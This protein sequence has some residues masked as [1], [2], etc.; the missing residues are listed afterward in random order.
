MQDTYTQQRQE[1]IDWLV[2][3]N[4]PA[5]PVAPAQN[6][7]D[8][9]KVVQADKDKGV[10]EHCP[11]TSQLKPTPLY[12][13][14]NPSYLDR[15]GKPHLVNHRRY[16]KQL[17]S[18]NE[19][20]EWF[21]HP[22][23]GIG[24]LGSW[25]NTV[26]LDFDVKKFKSQVECNAVAFS[27]AAKVQQQTDQDAFLERSHSGGWRIGVRVR[28]QPDFTN[29]ALTPGG[30]H[31]G[32]ALGEGRFTV[33]SPTVGPSGNSYTSHQRSFPPLVESLE[34]IGIYSTKA[35]VTPSQTEYRAVRV[36]VTPGTIPLE[37][38]GDAASRDVLTGA[39]STGDRSEALATAIQ[40][41]FGWQNWCNANGVTYSGSTQELA[42]RA[43]AALN[44]DSDR[45][46]RILN[47]KQA[48]DPASCQ[49]AALYRGGEASCWKKIYRLDRGSFEA[50]CP[51]PLREDIKRE[52]RSGF[53]GIPKERRP[54]GC[55]NSSNGS[56]GN[57]NDGDKGDNPISVLSANP[58]DLAQLRQE[59]KETLYRDLPPSVLQSAK[60]KL[61]T[62]N[63]G[64]SERE[65]SRLFDATLQE[66]E[67]EESR[68]ERVREV[69]ELLKLGDMSLD[70]ASFLP[71]DLAIPLTRWCF[72]LS[73]RPAVALTALLTG[74]SS[75]HAPGTEL[76]I[77][78]KRNFTVPPSIYAGLVS[79]SGQRKSPVFRTLLRQP[80]GILH[81]EER[82]RYQANMAQ[83]EEELRKYNKKTKDDKGDPP[84]KPPAQRVYFF[85]DA[86]GEGIK[87]Q[88]AACPNKGLLG[89]IDELAGLFKSENA[90]RN[91][92]GSDKQDLLSYF[93]TTGQVV[94]R[95]NGIKADVDKVYLSLFGTIQPSIL[96]DFM[97]DCTDPDGQWARFLFVN[98]PLAA[99]ELDDDDEGGIDIVQLLTNYYHQIDRLPARKYR[100]SRAAFCRYQQVY[101]QL[102][103]L[104]VTHPSPGLSAV[105]GK[106]QG[107]IGRIA[108]NLHVLYSLAADKVLPDE[109]IP[110]DIMERA[111][112]LAKFY[113]GQTKIIHSNCAATE[114]EL[115]PHLVKLIEL[116][117][118]MEMTMGNGWIKAKPFQ[119]TFST[120]QR[121]SADVARSWMREAEALG[122]GRTR[123]RGIRLEF[124]WRSDFDNNSPIPPSL[125]QPTEKVG[126]VGSGRQKVGEQSTAHIST[127][128]ALQEKVV[129][130]SESTTTDELIAVALLEKSH[131][132]IQEYVVANCLQND[133]D[134]HSR[135]FTA[136]DAL[137]TN[138]LPVEESTAEPEIPSLLPEPVQYEY[139][140]QL[141]L[142]LLQIQFTTLTEVQVKY[143][144]PAPEFTEYN[145]Q[146]T[147][148][149]PT[150][151]GC[152][153]VK[154]IEY[155]EHQIQQERLAAT[156]GATALTDESS[157]DEAAYHPGGVD[158]YS[159]C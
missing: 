151:V 83:Y 8:Y 81:G 54:L 144:S 11:L 45:I 51:S 62:D 7:Y 130:V 71:P 15:R 126:T 46:G 41:W 153:C 112:A 134:A 32:E 98:Q 100:L 40:E 5:L 34:A 88:A 124:H 109:E 14:K 82:E 99:A 102:E 135:G 94:L 49:P 23:V 36:H 47:P 22:K 79:P 66:L 17:P 123:G 20:S 143:T 44:I 117:R 145:Q 37:E 78:K 63:P 131:Q 103:K 75:L 113:I 70:L 128:I 76:T 48:F 85:T 10:W 77:S 146:L 35:P 18:A 158:R 1:A 86:N 53:N 93:D 141:G 138:S 24:T 114:G 21:H 142:W 125:A 65:L 156:N 59:I 140:G 108:L 91:G 28:C 119:L 50:R 89:L 97:K 127:A 132:Q 55:D 29:F 57:G 129:G 56:H 9:H 152:E 107:Y 101:N 6:V 74:L 92:R 139:Q 2:A 149:T 106:M 96:C 148:N 104:R 26:W 137:P 105:Y 147:V 30:T 133:G 58:L 95:T 87:A 80:L 155:L 116:S 19:L 69:D 121:P 25:N 4:Y 115:A 3:H 67:L 157:S 13:G 64:V 60:I 154:W 111:I 27:I 159:S 38:L 118:R 39:C 61:R 84:S 120:K 43:G 136:V 90:Y 72:W 33:L 110:L 42:Y 68:I 150:E 16:Q 73:I 52:L 31:V 12:T 122:F